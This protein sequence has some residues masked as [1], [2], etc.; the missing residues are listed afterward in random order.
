MWTAASLISPR[1]VQ[2]HGSH[3]GKSAVVFD[4]EETTL[5]NLDPMT[6]ADWGYQPAKFF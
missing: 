5:S 6:Q 2:P 3:E 4:I 1:L